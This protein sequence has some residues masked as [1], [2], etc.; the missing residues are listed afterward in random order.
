MKLLLN[1]ELIDHFHN[2]EILIFLDLKQKYKL[3]ISWL[4][5]YY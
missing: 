2:L 1:I 3:I 4:F 5:S